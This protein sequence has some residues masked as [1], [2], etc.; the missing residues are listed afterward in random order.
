MNLGDQ[1]DGKAFQFSL[2][3]KTLLHQLTAQSEVSNSTTSRRK[4]LTGGLDLS[5]IRRSFAS[6]L[7]VM[8][9][10]K[11]A[12][13]LSTSALI[14][15]GVNLT[16]NQASSTLRTYLKSSSLNTKLDSL[17]NTEILLNGFFSIQKDIC[18]CSV[19]KNLPSEND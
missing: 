4:G 14:P 13:E 6:T 11:K 12:V 1:Q 8:E 3:Y 17:S 16:E 7:N 19:L 15:S 5:S 18:Y 10:G 2:L 9:D